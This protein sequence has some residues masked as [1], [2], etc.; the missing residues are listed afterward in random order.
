MSNVTAVAAGDHHAVAIASELTNK[1]VL[2]G[3]GLEC[4]DWTLTQFTNKPTKFGNM[5]NI[6]IT[7]VTCGSYHTL[8]IGNGYVYRGIPHSCG[9]GTRGRLGHDNVN[10]LRLPRCIYKLYDAWKVVKKVSAGK[11]HSAF[12]TTEGEVFTCGCNWFGQLGYFTEEEYSVIPVN[13]D[14]GK[15]AAN[16]KIRCV[17]HKTL[18]VQTAVSLLTIY[19]RKVDVDMLNA[20]K[21]VLPDVSVSPK[22]SLL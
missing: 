11:K 4:S 21:S 1:G 19:Q 14:L 13:V 16:I 18:F 17:T 15:N 8:C 6:A 7:S 20:V 3:W 22:S 5:D 9:R 12:L 2:Y 10:S